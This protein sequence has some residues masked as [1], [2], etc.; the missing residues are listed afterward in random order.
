MI[1]PYSLSDDE[2]WSAVQARDRRFDGR[3]VIG[4]L[5]TGIYCRTFSR[6]GWRAAQDGRQ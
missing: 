6:L 4:V 3:F 1:A 2:A 5:T